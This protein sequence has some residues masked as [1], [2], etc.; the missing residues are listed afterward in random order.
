[1]VKT[2]IKTNTPATHILS[3]STQALTRTFESLINQAKDGVPAEKILEE[4]NVAIKYHVNLSRENTL[5]YVERDL[6]R[7]I[8]TLS[9]EMES[10]FDK[11][12]RD[13]TKSF[14]EILGDSLKDDILE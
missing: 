11:M 9:P 6:G 2:N 12:E 14:S 8:S 10:E 1:M 3:I 7:S 13:F 4:A 5:Q